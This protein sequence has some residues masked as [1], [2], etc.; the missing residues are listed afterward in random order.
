M[1]FGIG[2]R[3]SMS[4]SFFNPKT[5]ILDRKSTR[6]NSSHVSISYAVFC[7]KKKKNKNQKIQRKKIIKII[8][9]KTR[10]W[11][12]LK[13]YLT[14]VIKYTYI[15]RKLTYHNYRMTQLTIYTQ[16]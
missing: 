6:L 14:Y 11:L 10:T 3:N 5:H 4:F 1:C 9:K 7:L 13:Y 12:H 8:Q 16:S 2:T 15:N